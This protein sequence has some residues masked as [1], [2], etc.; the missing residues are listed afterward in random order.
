MKDID[1]YTLMVELCKRVSDYQF[2]PEPT[3]DAVLH[4]ISKQLGDLC[5]LY[6]ELYDHAQVYRSAFEANI[7]ESE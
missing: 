6:Q 5:A 7:E 3:H 2:D 1:T 4:T